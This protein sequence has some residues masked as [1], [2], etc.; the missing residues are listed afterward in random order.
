[1]S[2]NLGSEKEN[3]LAK[4]RA[5]INKELMKKYFPRKMIFEEGQIIMED[6]YVWA[7]FNAL[8]SI[9]FENRHG[10]TNG[11]MS[12]YF[13]QDKEGHLQQSLENVTTIDNYMNGFCGNIFDRLEYCLQDSS[14]DYSHLSETDQAEVIKMAMIRILAHFCKTSSFMIDENMLKNNLIDEYYF[15]FDET[16]ELTSE[17]AGFDN[18]EY[19]AKNITNIFLVLSNMQMS[20]DLPLEKKL[21]LVTFFDLFTYYKTGEISIENMEHYVYTALNEEIGDYEYQELIDCD[22]IDNNKELLLLVFEIEAIVF[23]QGTGVQIKDSILAVKQK[24]DIVE[25]AVNDTLNQGTDSEEYKNM[26]SIILKIRED[27]EIRKTI[28]EICNS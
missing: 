18:F 20:K 1:M 7:W 23:S 14:I 19:V 10:N 11:L 4:K 15:S 8:D 28:E 22:N 25:N 27:Y 12:D 16:D 21:L 17:D 6:A 26:F 2:N 3:A 5:K 9:L 24:R 13:V